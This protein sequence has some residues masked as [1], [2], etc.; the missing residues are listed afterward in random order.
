MVKSGEA[1]PFDRFIGS[2]H[3]TSPLPPCF[4]LPPRLTGALG[5]RDLSFSLS[6]APSRVLLYILSSADEQQKNSRLENT[7]VSL[8]LNRE[9]VNDMQ[10]RHDVKCSSAPRHWLRHS[11][12]SFCSSSPFDRRPSLPLATD[13]LDPRGEGGRWVVTG[14]TQ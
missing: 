3:E 4:H 13:P 12:T 6:F 10:I 11:S 8:Q 5:S 14:V 2:V 9:Y 7:N 1:P